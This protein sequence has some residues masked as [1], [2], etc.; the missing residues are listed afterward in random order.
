MA[1]AFNTAGNAEFAT[2]LKVTAALGLQLH[3]SPAVV[4]VVA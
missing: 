3:V 2:I 1:K 4:K